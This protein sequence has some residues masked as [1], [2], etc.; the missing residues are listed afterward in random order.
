M[1]F[2]QVSSAITASDTAFFGAAQRLEN[3][4]RFSF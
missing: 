2:P 1:R 4:H 3:W